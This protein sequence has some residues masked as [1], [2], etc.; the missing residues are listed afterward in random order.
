MSQPGAATARV[1]TFTREIGML[2]DRISGRAVNRRL[3]RLEQLI[4]G[5]RTT[6]IGDNR[7]LMGMSAVGREFMFLLDA[8]DLLLTPSVV[9][10]GAYDGALS[11]YLARTIAPDSHSIDVGTNFGYYSCLL[12]TLSP[13]GR[14]IGIEAEERCVTLARENLRINGLIERAR[15]IH[16]AASRSSDDLTLYRRSSRSGN[17]SICF[18]DKDFTDL[19]GELPV[20]PFRVK[21]IRIDDLAPDLG[22]RVD[23][24]KIDVEGAEPLVLEGARATIAANPHIRIAM[25]WSPGQVAHGG[26][27]VREFVDTIF[28]MG[29]CAHDMKGNRLVPL[30][31]AALASLPYRAAIILMRGD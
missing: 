15:I 22:G 27:E 17:T 26:T 29:L 3:N 25:E 24:V 11:R 12:G 6:Y 19:M 18:F 4:G 10:S 31:A 2:W 7:L 14:V 30:S 1:A 13:E 5:A 28:G 8:G 16:A 9:T 21:G 20:E 23:F